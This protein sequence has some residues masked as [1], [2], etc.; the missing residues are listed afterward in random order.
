MAKIDQIIPPPPPPPQ[1][2]LKEKIDKAK[3]IKGELGKK[4]EKGKVVL[5]TTNVKK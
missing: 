2:P 5:K 1:P 4:I 3:I